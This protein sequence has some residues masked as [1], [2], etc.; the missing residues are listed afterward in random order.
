V[1][2][3]APGVLDAQ[4]VPRIAEVQFVRWQAAL[5]VE[6]VRNR[7]QVG[8]LPPARAGVASGMLNVSREVFGLLGITI[9]GAIVSARQ[10]AVTGTVLHRFLEGYQF[11]LVVAVAL[12]ALG[13]PVSLFSLG[14]VRPAEP[15]TV[16][17]EPVLEP[18]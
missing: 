18:V 15:V 6:R 12:V 16:P 17:E 9:L 14:R 8:V 2:G 3:R 1:G 5:R 13:V 11:A 4:P 7:V 10:N